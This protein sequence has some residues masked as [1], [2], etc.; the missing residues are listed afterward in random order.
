[1][2]ILHVTYIQTARIYIRR[3]VVLHISSKKE[4]CCMLKKYMIYMR[5]GGYTCCYVAGKQAE[6]KNTGY[7]A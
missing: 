4:G 2:Y 5:H 1:M 7:M 3:S 6:E